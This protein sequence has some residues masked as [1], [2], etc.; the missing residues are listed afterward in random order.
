[1]NRKYMIIIVIISCFLVSCAQKP[2]V[3][4]RN[5]VRAATSEHEDT[6]EVQ[7]Q[8]TNEIITNIPESISANSVT[9][10]NLD[11]FANY[12]GTKIERVIDV[13]NK[14]SLF[15]DAVIDV[16]GIN[17]V[18]QYEYL[19]KD[20]TEEVR[21]NL[22]QSVFLDAAD[23][24]EYDELN[25]VWTLD[26]DP[27]IR[28]YF[29]YQV[30]YSN[31]GTTVSGEQIII[32]ENRYYDLYPFEDNRLSTVSDSKV[33]VSIDAAIGICKRTVNAI[34]NAD[35]YVADCVQGYGNNGRRPY[36]KIVFRY[37]LDG[38]PVSGYN[39]LTFLFDNNGIEMVKGSLFSVKEIGL[40]KNIL[41]PDEAV[42]RLQEQADFLIFEDESQIMVSK[43]TLEYIVINSPE[44]KMLITPVWRFWLGNDEDERNFLCHKI[45]AI[46]A[47]TGEL[48]WDERGHTM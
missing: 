26:I 15:I 14:E 30:S 43:V 28:N 29:L 48:I 37:T 1:M 42:E 46:D 5:G 24:A 22:F 19:T 25:D 11:I 20:I 12:E 23:E 2:N 33:D 7:Q 4:E 13:L 41:S 6:E 38:M 16:D 31:G 27:D 18:S 40:T 47:L 9:Q 8:N 36:Y 35:N 10:R 17:R 21:A 44:G 32:L 39:D 45:L 34:T 3:G